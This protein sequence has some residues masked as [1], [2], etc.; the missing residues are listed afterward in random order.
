MERDPGNGSRR[1]RGEDRLDY[2]ATG[3]KAVGCA[4]L[5]SLL[6]LIVYG[7]NAMNSVQYRYKARVDKW[8]DGDTVDL[9]VDLGFHHYVKTRFRLFGIDTPERGDALWSEASD[10]AKNAAP[11]GTDVIIDVFKD[12]DKYGRWLVNIHVD[13]LIVNDALVAAGLAVPYFGGTKAA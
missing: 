6:Q 2:T 8:V 13:G 1:S 9:Y 11:V 3:N 12:A 10:F 7:R 4:W 5:T